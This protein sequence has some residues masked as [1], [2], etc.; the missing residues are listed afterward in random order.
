M[1]LNPQT[2]V[3][4]VASDPPGLTVALN[5]EAGPGTLTATLIAGSKNTVAAES[6]QVLGGQTYRFSSWSDGGAAAHAFIANATGTLT[7]RFSGSGGSAGPRSARFGS[8][9]SETEGANTE[10][11]RATDP[12]RGAGEA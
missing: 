2:V 11:G 5:S 3:V 1:T 8:Q 9:A 6:P 4:T 7:A 12:A 10:V